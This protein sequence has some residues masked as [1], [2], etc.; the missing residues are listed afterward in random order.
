LDDESV[1]GR[2]ERRTFDGQFGDR[3]TG[4]SFENLLPRRTQAHEHLT[5]ITTMSA[6]LDHAL[7]HQPIHQL[8]GGVVADLQTVREHAHRRRL[9]PLEALD[10][11]QNEV[12]LGLHTGVSGGD[13]PDPQ[14]SSNLI[15]QIGERSVVAHPKHLLQ[16]TMRTLK[17]L[18]FKFELL[19]LHSRY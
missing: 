14:E 12:L 13:F 9:V 8:N 18:A 17:E 10:L 5:S 11:Q 2:H 6:P 19:P 1:Q 16:I 15:A 3:I 7:P 4:E